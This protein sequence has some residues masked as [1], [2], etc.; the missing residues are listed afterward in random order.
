MKC[1]SSFS[2][3]SSTMVCPPPPSWSCSGAGMVISGTAFQSVHIEDCSFTDSAC[4]LTNGACTA[5]MT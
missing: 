3:F 1:A 5:G 2:S 4:A